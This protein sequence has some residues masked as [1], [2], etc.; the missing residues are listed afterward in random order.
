MVR[1]T[2]RMT[3]RPAHNATDNSATKTSPAD[4]KCAYSR[5]RVGDLELTEWARISCDNPECAFTMIH[6]CCLEEVE[7]NS[8]TYHTD[9]HLNATEAAKACWAYKRMSTKTRFADCKCGSHWEPML[10]PNK[11]RGNN[12]CR[13]IK[14]ASTAP[15]GK[16]EVVATNRPRVEDQERKKKIAQRAAA[17]AAAAAVIAAVSPRKTAVKAAVKAPNTGVSKAPGH[18]TRA[19]TATPVTEKMAPSNALSPTSVVSDTATLKKS[20]S[21][22]GVALPYTLAEPIA[23]LNH[24]F[25]MP[26]FPTSN[27]ESRLQAWIV[28]SELNGD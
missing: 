11:Q 1:H 9:R 8:I 24:D 20:A 28:L 10:D 5:C 25:E 22:D 14:P 2:S 19:N 15:A 7:D 27:K 16:A 17:A 4:V 12:V 6:A 23:L 26:E 13:F 21:D 18:M 3:T